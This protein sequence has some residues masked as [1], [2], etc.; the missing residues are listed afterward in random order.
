MPK[1]VTLTPEQVLE[2]LFLV[3]EEIEALAGDARTPEEDARFEV[4]N[5]ARSALYD[6]KP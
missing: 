4:L 5:G 1:T 6:P 3:N 2:I